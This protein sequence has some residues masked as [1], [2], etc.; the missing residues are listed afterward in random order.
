MHWS[1]IETVAEGQFRLAVLGDG[2]DADLTGKALRA[3]LEQARPNGE[4]VGVE[5]GPEEFSRC[6]ERLIELG[7]QG[8]SISNPFKPEAAKL[9]KQ[10]FI[11]RHGLGVANALKL[12]RDIYAQNTEVPAFTSKIKD[13]KPGLA[14]VM[15]SGRAARS[16]VMSLFECGWRIR[17][18]NRNIIRSRPLAVAFETYGKVDL[19]SQPDPFGCSLIVNATPLGAKAGEQPPVK[20]TNSVPKTTAIDFVYRTVATEYLRSASQRG[21]KTVDGKELLVEQAALALEWWLGEAV[22]REPMLDAV[23]VRGLRQ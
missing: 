17:V 19:C 5:C 12:G 22:P 6:I 11:V 20:W 15:G 18:W 1:E 3:A 8:A 23:G 2:S 10:F 4:V 16:A 21:F 7:F 14:L 9:A 13:L